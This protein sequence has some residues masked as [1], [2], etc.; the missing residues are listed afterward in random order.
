MTGGPDFIIVPG[1]SEV[2]EVRLPGDTIVDSD[3]KIIALENIQREVVLAILPGAEGKKGDTGGM[4]TGL[5]P[6]AN[7][8]TPNCDITDIAVQ[9]N[10]QA[11]GTLTINAPV[12]TPIEGKKLLLRIKSTNVQ[13]CAWNP[14][15][16]GS[17]DQVLPTGTTG[18]LKT[19]YI[20][21]SYN[22]TDATW[23]LV[24]KNFGF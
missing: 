12:G 9:I 6:D 20:G 15:Y 24:G 2:I 19:D 1:K 4:R 14:V 7:S 18:G 21:F 16:R 11:A 10:T 17:L 3:G 22:S 13:A 8:L 5:L 23:D